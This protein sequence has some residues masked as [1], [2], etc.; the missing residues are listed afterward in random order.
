MAGRLD[1]DGDVIAFTY[2][3]SYLER[4]EAIPLYLPELPLVPGTNYPEGREIAGCIS[5]AGPDS[6][7]RRVLENKVLGDPSKAGELGT[8]DY[9]LESGSDRIGAL[10][11]Q[12]SSDDYFA[13]THDQATL[14]DLVESAEKVENGLP[15][16]PALDAA[17]LQG[18][19]VGGA[20][21][22]ALI[23]L[24]ERRMIA[25]FSSKTD[26]YAVVKG[27]YVAME[28]ARRAGVRVANVELTNALGKDVLL[29]ERFDRIPGGQRRAMVSALTVL[30][31][32]EIAGRYASYADLAEVIRKRFTDPVETL[33]E[34]FARITFNILVGN[35]DDH[36][37]NH[38]AFWDGEALSLTPAFDVGPQRRSGGEAEQIMA[39]GADGTR[40]SQVAVCVKWARVYGIFSESDAREIIDGQIEVIRSEWLD[41]CELGKLTYVERQSLWG[42][43]FLNQYALQGY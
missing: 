19:S 24:G 30:G 42:V 37:R 17:L 15:L 28:L 16:T 26:T 27:E 3:R 8:L 40:W 29:V 33:R 18:S 23:S 43:Q 4:K 14:E 25:K 6:W 13:R 35:T 11:F 7:G 36:A 12:H 39:I 31:L 10:D 5:D 22:K 41:V 32:D 9:L 38:A 34:L 21:P 20:R 2:G 1:V